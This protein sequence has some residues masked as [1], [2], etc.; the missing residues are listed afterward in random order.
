[1]LI[2]SKNQLVRWSFAPDGKRLAYQELNPRTTG[3]DI[4]TVPIEVEGDGLR[5]GKPES[6]LQTS[7][8]ERHPA[9]SPDGRWLAYTS[10]ESGKYEVYVRAFPDKGGKWQISNAG[11]VYPAWSGNGHELFFRADDNRIM[12][13]P[14]AAK[15]D[16]FVP[17]RPR[18]WSDKQL[19]NLGLM[20]IS[21]Y[22]LARD[23]KRIAAL[24]PVETPRAQKAQNHVVFLENFSDELRRKVPVGK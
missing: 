17:D 15:A 20:G 6:F 19:A 10:N 5:A 21:N 16:S 1:L 9:I 4:W 12:V 3:N 14:Y 13:A 8:D 7:A 11:G 2:Q 18:V 23:G 24:M 22:D